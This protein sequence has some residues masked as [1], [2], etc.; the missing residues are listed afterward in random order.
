VDAFVAALTAGLLALPQLATMVS[1]S[2]P[3]LVLGAWLPLAIGIGAG[4]AQ[5]ARSRQRVAAGIVQL[6]RIGRLA[7]ALALV[8]GVAAAFAISLLNLDR[9][10]DAAQAGIDLLLQSSGILLATLAAGI[11]VGSA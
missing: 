8:L 5:L 3:T 9:L 1:L 4:V 7:L 2:L 10:P 11:L 6:A